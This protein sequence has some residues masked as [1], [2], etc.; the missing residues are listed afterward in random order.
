MLDWDKL[1]KTAKD[2]VIAVLDDKA[3]YTPENIDNAVE[4]AITEIRERRAFPDNYTGDQIT[5]D[6]KRY[7]PNIVSLA[8]YD[9]SMMGGEFET[10]HSE[11]DVSRT[12]TERERCF[13]GIVPIAKI[14]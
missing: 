3:L 12:Y 10:S 7:L 8:V 6:M 4:R 9:L 13:S 11:S 1:N 5:R 14:I 2:R